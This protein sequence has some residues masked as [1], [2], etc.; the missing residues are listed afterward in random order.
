[1]PHPAET[2]LDNRYGDCKDHVTLLE[3]LLTAAGIESTPALIN[4]GNAYRLPSAPSLGVL[5]HVITY[6]P[7]LDLFLDSTA[8]NVEFGY[9]PVADLG[10]PVLLTKT[11]TLA[12]TPS[13]QFLRLDHQLQIKVA[14]DGAATFAFRA[15]IQ[16]AQAEL[17]RAGM[18]DARP[19]DRDQVVRRWLQQLRLEGSGTLDIG[20][21]IDTEGSY[22]LRASG[23]I[24]D[25]VSFP[26][27]VALPLVTSIAGGIAT[28]V[29]NL[30]KEAIRTQPFECVSAELEETSEIDLPGSTSIVS[31]PKGTSVTSKFFDFRSEYRLNGLKVSVGRTYR[32]HFPSIVCQSADYS[33]MKPA[34]AQIMNDLRSQMIVRRDSEATPDTNRQ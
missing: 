12:S 32:S 28:T 18:R 9:L 8:T 31:L 7:T 26:G 19:S 30:S 15:E 14:P 6:I 2:I 3:A 33:D 20:N 25:L 24:D 29:A 16:G 1:V 4:L 10:K 11:G 21:V 13:S 17:A 27:P 22:Q 5:N 23:K 34:L